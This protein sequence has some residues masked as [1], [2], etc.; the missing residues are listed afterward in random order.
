MG[1]RIAITTLGSL[2]DINPM[3]G[4]AL[5]LRGRG[6][7]VSLS[8]S[9]YFQS[10]VEKHGIGFHEVLPDLDPHGEGLIQAMLDPKRGPERLHREVI[11]PHVEESYRAFLEVA[12]KADLI[13]SGILSYFAPLCA[14]KL[15][16]PW[17]SV[18]LSPMTFWSV[19][20]PPV[21]P[22]MEFLRYA[23]RFGPDFNRFLF[24]EIFRVSAEWARPVQELRAREG[25][26]DE[27]NPLTQGA[28]STYLNLGMYSRLLGEVQPDFPPNTLLT[29][30]VLFDQDLTHQELS[31]ALQDFLGSGEPPV[32]FTLGSTCV[33]KHGRLFD[34]FHEVASKAGSR[35]VVLTGKINY[36]RYRGRSSGKVFFEDY[37]PF[38]KLFPHASCI[39]HQG[40]IGTTGQAMHSGKPM[41]ILPEVN[42]Q[43]DNLE[44]VKRLGIAKGIQ[45]KRVNGWRLRSAIETILADGAYSDRA[46]RVSRQV[47]GESGVKA[48]AD[49]IEKLLDHR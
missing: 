14:R 25:I 44:R 4:L 3:L 8:T 26:Q 41:V 42:D 22:T 7:E 15:G 40:G 27:S 17:A 43:H 19:Y 9:R 49:A 32:V 13:V 6:H 16:K 30:F 2:G 21:I 24:R 48:A 12:G 18:M 39:V 10:Y 36:E 35:A 11:F 45:M 28:A 23:Y 31:P 5:E 29:G 37:A 1:K 33:M 34:L 20:D 47:R 38:S 46:A